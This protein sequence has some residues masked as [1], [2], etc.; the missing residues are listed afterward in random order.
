MFT[1][2]AHIDPFQRQHH[3]YFKDMYCKSE[4]YTMLSF[5]LHFKKLNAIKDVGFIC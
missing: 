5:E 4:T 1:G 2:I 3:I